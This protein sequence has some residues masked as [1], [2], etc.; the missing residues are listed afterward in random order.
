MENVFDRQAEPILEVAR[1]VEHPDFGLCLDMGHAHCYSDRP[2]GAWAELFGSY[3]K[4]LHVHDNWGTGM[5]TGDWEGGTWII[6]R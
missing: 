4:H 5:P 1:K 6:K 3:I 2:A